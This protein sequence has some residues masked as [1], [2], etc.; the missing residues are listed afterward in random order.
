MFKKLS[1][2]GINSVEWHNKNARDRNI[3]SNI[4][5]A[6]GYIRKQKTQSYYENDDNKSVTTRASSKRST[7]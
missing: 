4:N 3:G 6:N 7:I 2:N 5:L 1:I